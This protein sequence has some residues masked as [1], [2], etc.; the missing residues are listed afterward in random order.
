MYTRPARGPSSAVKIGNPAFAF[1]LDNWAGVR[2]AHGC[3]GSRDGGGV[4]LLG[5]DGKFRRRAGGV[6]RE[7]HGAAGWKAG[8]RSKRERHPA[9]VGV[10]VEVAYNMCDKTHGMVA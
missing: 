5:A 9:Q 10:A 4:Q 8:R 3:R 6:L 7:A 1:A 2:G